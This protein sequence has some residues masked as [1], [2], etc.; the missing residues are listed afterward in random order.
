MLVESCASEK[1]QPLRV[2]PTSCNF[3]PSNA[4]GPIVFQNICDQPSTCQ[5]KHLWGQGGLS[6]V[7]Q[8]MQSKV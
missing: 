5:S 4:E 1:N 3:K 7:K 2:L 6:L 8:Q